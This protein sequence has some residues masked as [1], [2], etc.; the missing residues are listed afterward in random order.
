M[1]TGLRIGGC[2]AEALARRFG[3]PLFA[4]DEGAVVERYRRFARAFAS[5]PTRLCYALKANPLKGLARAL[6]REGA[7]CD[8]VSGGELRR[9]LAAGFAAGRVV[10]SG[11]GKTEEELRL[12]LSVGVGTFNVESRSELELLARVARRTRRTARF[13]VRLSPGVRAGGH[14]HIVTGLAETKFGVEATEAAALY[15]WALR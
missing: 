13:A 6:A 9:A 2:P 11:V 4:Y 5:R 12:G 1:G 3:T 8:V 15:R 14:A 10:F 7:G